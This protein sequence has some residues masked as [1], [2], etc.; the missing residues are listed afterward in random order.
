MPAP[1]RSSR[2]QLALLAILAGWFVLLASGYHLNFPTGTLP[3]HA[4]TL[5]LAI[6]ILTAAAGIG[7]QLLGRILPRRPEAPLSYLLALGLGLGALALLVLA[8]LAAGLTSPVVGWL[9]CAAGLAAAW[10]SF[11]GWRSAWS[12]VPPLCR[13]AAGRRW[14]AP[15]IA[16]AAAGWLLALGAALAPA[17]F[18][19][20]L[21]YHLAVPDRYLTAGGIH[22]VE[23]NFYSLFPANQGML[24]AL[25]ILIRGDRAA[26]GSLAQVLHL[27]MGALAVLAT[28]TIGIR[29]LSPGVAV[30][31]ACL[32]AVVPGFLLIAT[33][34]IADLAVTFHAALMIAS[35]LEAEAAGSAPLRRRWCLLAGLLAGLALGTKYTAFASVLV[36]ALAWLAWRARRLDRRRAADLAL[37][38]LAAAA[39]FAPWAVKNVAVAGNPVAPYFSGLFGAA[40][41]GPSLSEELARRGPEAGTLA[42]RAEHLL[43]APW[44]IGTERL[45]AGGYLGV[46]FL[47]MLPFLFLRRRHPPP[48]PALAIMAI[49]AFLAWSATVQVTRYLFPVLPA[50]ALLA[51]QGAAALVDLAPRARYL[52]GALVGWL[53]IH[54]VY[55]FAV[56]VFTI[57]PF[58]VVV[59][60]ESPSDYLARRVAYY[61]A[62]AQ[63]NAHLPVD[64]RILLVGEGR[65]YYIER[66]YAASTPFDPILVE[67]F[68]AEAVRERL[69]LAAFLRR[70][71]FSHLLV[72]RAEMARVADL[73]GRVAFVEAPDPALGVAVNSLISGRGTRA[74]FTR[75]SVAVLEIVGE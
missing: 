71:G 6:L 45:G 48:V 13:D 58:G 57:N 27:A 40:V 63:I 64:A 2:Y 16:V 68:A 19:D 38:A 36:P 56:L 11:P 20:A 32:M 47:L 46:S 8:A 53:M 30:L 70:E 14:A 50:L 54:G 67:R 29:R 41:S 12:S 26:A 62:A 24:Y 65:G 52:V 35:L 55:L 42:A 61:P 5:L 3:G 21:I 34:P 4:L 39:L 23:G 44:R 17:Q 69:D 73:A 49:F 66:E 22:A 74:L 33:Y 7:W 28:F 9:V 10:R 18:Y 31:G 25:A 37:F 72:N 1:D 43:L 51:A 75:G 15:G 59:G 60:V